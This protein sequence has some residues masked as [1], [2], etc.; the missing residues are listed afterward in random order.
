LAYNALSLNNSGSFLSH[1]P[2][3]RKRNGELEY[4]GATSSIGNRIVPYTDN[5]LVLGD[6]VV[7]DPTGYYSLNVPLSSIEFDNTHVYIP[8]FRSENQGSLVN[9][10][11][12]RDARSRSTIS[13][14]NTFSVD[15]E[16]LVGYD[17]LEDSVW[18]SYPASNTSITHTFMLPEVYDSLAYAIMDDHLY[19]HA[20]DLYERY[21][22][23]RMYSLSDTVYLNEL[24]NYFADSTLLLENTYAVEI[25]TPTELLGGKLFVDEVFETLLDT[26]VITNHIRHGNSFL[27]VERF[28]Y[29]DKTIHLSENDTAFE[30]A[31]NPL[32]LL[33]D[34]VN[35]NFNNGQTQYWYNSSLMA[36]PS[37]GEIKFSKTYPDYTSIGVSP[38]SVT[39]GVDRV[40]MSSDSIS[41][42]GVLDQRNSLVLDSIYIMNVSD[43]SYSK[44]SSDDFDANISYVPEFQ[45]VTCMSLHGNSEQVFIARK[46][47]P[48]SLIPS[49]TVQEDTP[50]MVSLSA[51]FTDPDSIPDDISFSLVG[52]GAGVSAQIMGDSIQII[53]DANY[54]GS[55]TITLSSTHDW[56]TV[57]ETFTIEVQ[58]VN[59]PPTISELPP[60]EMCPSDLLTVDYTNFL[61]DVDNDL[62]DL[63][64]VPEVIAVSSGNVST[65][66]LNVSSSGQS[67]TFSGSGLEQGV[68][69]LHV[70]THDGSDTSMVQ[71]LYVTFLPPGE[72]EIMASDT[73]ACL[74]QP[75][76]FW[77]TQGTTGSYLWEY[78]GLPYSFSDTIELIPNGVGAGTLDL[79]VRG[80]NGCPGEDEISIPVHVPPSLIV[81]P[82]EVEMCLGDSLLLA[83][84]GADFYSWSSDDT[85][86]PTAN[87]NEIIAIPT[88]NAVYAVH[89]WNS[90]SCADMDSVEI[91]MNAVPPSPE[92]VDLGST[93]YSTV[94]INIQWYLDGQMLV[95]ETGQYLTPTTSGTYTVEYTDQNG[96]SA[97]SEPVTWLITGVRG[98]E[99]T[100][101]NV[102]PNPNNGTFT[103]EMTSSVLLGY[104][105]FDAVGKLIES[106]PRSSTTGHITVSGISS[107]VYFLKVE[108]EN[109]VVVKKVVVR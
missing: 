8:Y 101:V 57:Q 89:G 21:V 22:H 4:L 83:A 14:Q 73:I 76:T 90:S 10:R 68:F 97:V 46:L 104:Q 64:M 49:I 84:S 41:L 20:F 96:C 70:Q 51:F 5:Q 88:T 86:L 106:T 29:Y 24:M 27:R 1:A 11:L 71:T 16:N 63:I 17:V 39:Y 15:A 80:W 58:P 100:S 103:I 81:E 102:Y 82:T 54:N 108:T 7:C 94:P 78:D 53:P 36:E 50:L 93:L 48:T 77:G 67:I 2:L 25:Q 85:F 61:S 43:G 12:V 87:S 66:D 109:G 95:G 52:T 79:F 18:V 56:L 74:G 72:I 92:I 40:T 31:M 38:L 3:Y 9:P 32:P 65:T 105:L 33:E 13:S 99:A 75:I 34:S 35:L 19:G 91:S 60:I 45:K 59:D 44:T 26:N 6:T 47:P 37:V 55:T 107:G 30:L 28:G 62:T 42:L 23:V 98:H 69:E